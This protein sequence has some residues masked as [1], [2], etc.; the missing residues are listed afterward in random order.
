MLAK[1]LSFL[2]LA[3]GY[4]PAQAE[5]VHQPY[6]DQL[7]IHMEDTES[8][9]YIPS[10]KRELESQ[11]PETRESYINDLKE[12]DP[13]LQESPNASPSYTEQE[14]IKLPYHSDEGAIEAVLA[15][16][17]E[18]KAKISGP[19]HNAIGMKF[20]I[21]LNR[22][23]TSPTQSRQFDEIYGGN[24]APNLSLYYEFQPF[25]NE[26]FGNV[27]IFGM[28]GICYYHGDGI[29]AVGL[30]RPAG[31]GTAFPAQANTQF[32]FFAAPVTIGLDYRFNL[33]RFLRPFIMAGPTT[34]GYVEM[35]NDAVAGSR[36]HGEG[37][38][39]SVGTL[40]LLDWFSKTSAWD[41]Y[42]SF[43]IKHS[44]L[45]VDFTRVSTLTGPI[46]YGTSGIMAGMT[47]EY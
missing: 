4:I 45:S 21:S 14:R 23:I 25:H 37:Y 29:F 24:S 10:L 47:F 3:L 44:Y 13:S 9:D 28:A 39:F 2:V 18:L 27:G 22:A 19:I 6:I 31:S 43:G 42:S 46:Q 15:D 36:G 17:S 1:A 7:K 41:L 34:V 8:N 35:R 33:F 32:Q 16:R 30:N 12:S 26:W 38:L 40:I 11:E 20:G 5:E